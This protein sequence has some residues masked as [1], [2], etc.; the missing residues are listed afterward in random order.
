MTVMS[1]V[2]W[3]VAS[4]AG[5]PPMIATAS[6]FAYATLLAL[7]DFI[8]DD[9][10]LLAHA[11]VLVSLAA[12]KWAFM[13]TLIH[14]LVDPPTV[15]SIFFSP[16]GFTSVTLLVS[17]TTLYY[18]A[19]TTQNHHYSREIKRLVAVLSVTA[20]FWLGTLGIDQNFINMRSSPTAIFSDPDR[21]EQVAL[22]I[23]WSIFALASIAAGFGWRTAGLRYFGL[24]LFAV[25]LLKV[26]SIDL[27]Q[28]STGYRI[29]SFMGLGILLL[30]TSVLYGK[31]SPLLLATKDE[32]VA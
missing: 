27:S 6:V 12:V 5:L 14:R 30:G 11:A 28:V 9:L 17:L 31:V 10:N 15:Q 18:R 23:F 25:T 29:L 16:G 1:S 20:L 26:V 22:S 2:L 3:V 21:A 32:R 19:A 13:D 7:M 8:D 4:L 24:V